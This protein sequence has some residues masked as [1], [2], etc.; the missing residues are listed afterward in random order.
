MEHAGIMGKKNSE[1][2]SQLFT[3]CAMQLFSTPLHL[4]GMNIY[5][6]PISSTKER[7]SFIRSE[8]LKTTAARIGI[9]GFN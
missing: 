3:P 2:C 7:W 1:L 8:Y 6:N 4:W 9:L 5:N